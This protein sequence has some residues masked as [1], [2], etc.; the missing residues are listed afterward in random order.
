MIA[1]AQAVLEYKH[2]YA[3]LTNES[4]EIKPLFRSFSALCEMVYATSDL[5][6]D[7]K[8]FY[9]AMIKIRLSWLESFAI[10]HNCVLDDGWAHIKVM[11][12]KYSI[13]EGVSRDSL[14]EYAKD[15]MALSA[16]GLQPPE[17]SA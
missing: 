15:K 3:E 1:Y 14:T 9:F 2:K 13:F 16:F 7:E 4:V 12:E 10:I 17:I 11:A 6:E 8:R 5:Q